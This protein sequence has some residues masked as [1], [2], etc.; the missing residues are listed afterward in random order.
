MEDLGKGFDYTTKTNEQRAYEMID[1]SQ[2]Q[3]QSHYISQ[4][5]YRNKF[6]KGFDNLPGFELIFEKMVANNVDKTPLAE[7]AKRTEEENKIT[8]YVNE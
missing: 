2:L 6:P 5:F 1:W 4:E 3:Y 7:Y 8:P